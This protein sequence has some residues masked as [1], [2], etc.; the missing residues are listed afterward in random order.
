MFKKKKSLQPYSRLYFL[1]PF[2]SQLSCFRNYSVCVSALGGEWVGS[3]SSVLFFYTLYVTSFC[4]LP[5]A[6]PAN[7]LGSIVSV[8]LQRPSL[9]CAYIWAIRCTQAPFAPDMSGHVYIC[10]KQVA[11]AFRVYIYSLVFHSPHHSLLYI[12]QPGSLMLYPYL[13]RGLILKARSEVVI[14]KLFFQ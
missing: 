2:P 8:V 4:L 14:F 12:L 6:S 5:A 13:C 3:F 11:A 7:L 1:S 10:W 9:S